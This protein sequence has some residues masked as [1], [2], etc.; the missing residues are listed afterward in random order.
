M[1]SKRE[2]SEALWPDV[3]VSERNLTAQIVVLLRR[4]G[5]KPPAL[6]LLFDLPAS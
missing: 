1:I 3:H 5:M 4:Q 6:D 2:L